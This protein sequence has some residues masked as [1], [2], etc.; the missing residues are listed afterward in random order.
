MRIPAITLMQGAIFSPKISGLNAPYRTKPMGMDTV[1]FEARSQKLLDTKEGAEAA[2][3]LRTSTSGYRGTLGEDFSDKLVYTITQAAITYAKEMGADT[4]MIGGDTRQATEKYAPAIRDLFLEQGINVQMPILEDDR[5]RKHAPVASPVLAV[6]TMK[7]KLPITVLLTASHNPWDEGGYNFL[8]DEGAVADG[9]VVDRL[10]ETMKRTT[11]KGRIDKRHYGE[12]GKVS[13]FNPYEI[14]AK[15]IKENNLIDFANIAHA[16]IDIYYEDFGGTGGYYLPRMMQE[17][18]VQLSGVL[19]S[20]TKGPEPSDENAAK[21]KEA[22][23]KS[24]NPLKIGIMTDGDSDRFGIVDENGKFIPAADVLTLASYHLIKNKGMKQGTIIKNCA[25]SDQLRALANYFNA[26][27]GFDIDV[28]DTPVGFK[29]LGGKMLELEHTSKPAILAGEE[30]GGFTIRGHI[31]EKDGFVAVSTIL[32]LVATEGKPVSEIL[33]EIKEKT[34]TQ[35][36]RTVNIGISFPRTKEGYEKQDK[37]VKG[38]EKYLEGAE[39]KLCGFEVDTERTKKYYKKMCAYKE[40]G[41]GLKIYLKDG[42]YALIRKSGTEPKIR[43]YV[44]TVNQEVYDTLSANLPKE[45][46]SYANS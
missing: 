1:S 23:T 22:I 19:H 34:A 10:V 40:G 39:D 13:T 38:F 27:E 2:E 32:D 30:S 18:G 42:S 20:R 33:K 17:N 9:N 31:P 24:T 16:G 4:V 12:K 43:I 28:E 41:D 35:N 3:K 26:Q 14:Y 36:Q 8:T 6:A 15:H 7:A 45:A 37:A 46:E 5:H 29:Y 44:D 11:H 21:L 25:T